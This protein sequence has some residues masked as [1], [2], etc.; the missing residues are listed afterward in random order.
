MKINRGYF[1]KK[2]LIKKEMRRINDDKCSL[3]HFIVDMNW[4]FWPQVW[5]V[6]VAE[7]EWNVFSLRF[8]HCR[9]TSPS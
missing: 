4:K 3:F 7:K 6:L 9:V 8:Q 5:K 2:S 1:R